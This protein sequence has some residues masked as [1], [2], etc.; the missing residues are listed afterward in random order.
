MR[1]HIFKRSPTRNLII[2]DSQARHLNAPNFNILSL[3]G[4]HIKHAY[5]FLPPAGAY[6]II[7]LF[8]GGNDLFSGHSPSGRAPELVAE[9]LSVLATRLSLLA[10]KVFVLGIPLR[11]NQF[12]YSC[13]VNRI[14][15]LKSK[16]SWSYRGISSTI[17]HNRH[18]KSDKVHL[19]DQALNSLRRVL[20]KKVLYQSFSVAIRQSGYLAVSDCSGVCTC[21]CFQRSIP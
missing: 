14:L 21:G 9:D 16:E 12:E 8:I 20:Q 4:G 11:Y 18:L 19:T 13:K 6:D 3:P 17:Y 7:V 1:Y 15:E 5:S 2:A 10:T